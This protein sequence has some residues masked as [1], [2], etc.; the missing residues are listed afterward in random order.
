M[1]ERFLFLTII[2][3]KNSYFVSIFYNARKKK[4]GKVTI[5]F[6]LIFSLVSTGINF[7]LWTILSKIIEQYSTNGGL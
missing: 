7:A 2:E 1:T 6:P 3:R 4:K 5:I